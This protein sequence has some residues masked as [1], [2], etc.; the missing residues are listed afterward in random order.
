MSTKAERRK[1]K[2]WTGQRWGNLVALK[3]VAHGVEGA[4]WRFACDCGHRGTYYLKQ[5]QRDERTT[6]GCDA[7]PAPK[8]AIPGRVYRM[9]VPVPTTRDYAAAWQAAPKPEPKPFAWCFPRVLGTD[10][11]PVSP[12]WRAHEN[13]TI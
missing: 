1:T 2:D 4:R 11:R 5:V 13:V 7:K 3:Y 6:C 12:I 8:P 10:G 9:G